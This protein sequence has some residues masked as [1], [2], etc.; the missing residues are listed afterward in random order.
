MKTLAVETSTLM[1]SIAIV[2]ERETLCELTLH[3]A[4]T[5]SAQLMPAIDYVL[6]DPAPKVVVRNFGNSSIDLQLRVWIPD[7]RKRM[8]TISDITDKIKEAF[9]RAGI[10]IPF[11]QRD[12][13]IIQKQASKNQSN[14]S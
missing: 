1:G 8:D 4:E 13:T 3:V 11:P 5:H 9:D 10:E 12:V 7:A 6:K 2:E 14:S